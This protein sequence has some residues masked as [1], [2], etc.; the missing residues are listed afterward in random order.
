MYPILY[1]FR[2][3]PY[4]MRA[5][6]A[7]YYAGVKVEL[8]EVVLREMP[9][10][11]LK[12]SPK[13]TV[14]VIVLPD[15]EVIDESWDIMQWALQQDDPDNWLGTDARLLAATQPLIQ[16]N[17][18]VFKDYL[19][20][21]KYADRYPEHTA[22]YYRAQGELFLQQLEE[23]LQTRLYLLG[24]KISVAD[25]AIFP[26]IRQFAFV[27]KEWFDNSTY[28]SLQDWLAKWLDSDLFVAI[29]GKYPVWQPDAAP[30]YMQRNI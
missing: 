19:D 23:R 9:Q 4:A 18:F 25:A 2:R 7:L 14:P 11:L 6:L 20:R 26:F 17:D 29:M 8:R 16:E 5:R 10:S 28:T 21:Y 22:A 1:S 3:C 13:A 30:I 27:D 12:A 15:G 24:D